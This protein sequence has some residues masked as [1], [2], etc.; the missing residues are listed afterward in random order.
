MRDFTAGDR[1]LH[2]PSKRIGSVV[3]ISDKS[4][5]SVRVD[6][7]EGDIIG[8][9]PDGRYNETEK[10]PAIFHIMTVDEIHEVET[11]TWIDL[12]LL[13][14]GFFGGYVCHFLMGFPT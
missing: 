5:Y 10:E 3:H 9:L 7:N 13:G 1:V 6:F 4:I 2:M 11:T 12:V 14:V 8:F